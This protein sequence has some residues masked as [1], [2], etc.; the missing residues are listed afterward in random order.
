MNGESRTEIDGTAEQVESRFYDHL[1]SE[2][3][4]SHHT[5]SAYRSDLKKLKLHAQPRGVNLLDVDEAMLLDFLATAECL[6]VY[7]L[8]CVPN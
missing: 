7:A 2:F 1:W 5:L 3:G 8:P 6:R 4:L